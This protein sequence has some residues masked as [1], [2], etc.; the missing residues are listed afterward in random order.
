MQT[1]EEKVDEFSAIVILK[2]LRLLQETSF[3]NGAPIDSLG[4]WS[5]FGNCWVSRNGTYTSLERLKWIF[6]RRCQAL[7]VDADAV[8]AHFAAMRAP[9]DDQSFEM[10]TF[11]EKLQRFREPVSHSEF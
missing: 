5:L 8:Q 1:L 4:H 7:R 9:E 2:G 6:E 3:G 11:D 10:L